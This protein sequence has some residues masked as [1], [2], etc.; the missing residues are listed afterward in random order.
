[1]SYIRRESEVLCCGREGVVGIMN[2][3]DKQEKRLMI[4][5]LIV[6]VLLSISM[7]RKFFT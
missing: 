3:F 4:V 6:V 7:L 2:K 5:C 1:M